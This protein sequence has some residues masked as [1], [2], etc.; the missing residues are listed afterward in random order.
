MGELF[1]EF[2]NIPIKPVPKPAIPTISTSEVGKEKTPS[3][4]QPHHPAMKAPY[5]VEKAYVESAGGEI[6]EGCAEHYSERIVQIE[7]EY[8]EDNHFL[9]ELKEDDF[10]KYI[11]MAEILK[12]KF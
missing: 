1:T 6:T 5:K 10:E 9:S 8:E 7:V 2:S 3:P 11:I 4:S 12:P